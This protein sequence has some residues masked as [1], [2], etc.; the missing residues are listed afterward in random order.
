MLWCQPSVQIGLGFGLAGNDRWARRHSVSGTSSSFQRSLVSTLAFGSSLADHAHVGW[1]R[2]V[3][4]QLLI[5]LLSPSLSIR[6][7]ALMHCS[8]ARLPANVSI[9][10]DSPGSSFLSRLSL[11]CINPRQQP[12]TKRFSR[13]NCRSEIPTTWNLDFF[14]ATLRYDRI[15]TILDPVNNITI[16]YNGKPR[17]TRR[18][19]E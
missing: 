18:T 3:Y 19:R 16:A 2:S 1:T 7:L 12:E 14:E 8:Q 15:P 9:Q 13:T 17:K 11:H 10:S 5:L 4:L 6:T